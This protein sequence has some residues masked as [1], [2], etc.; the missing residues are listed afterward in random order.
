[1]NSPWEIEFPK[2][3]KDSTERS[4]TTVEMYK[5]WL[6]FIK[7]PLERILLAKAIKKLEEETRYSR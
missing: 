1:M 4:Y 7:D 3:D 6:T 2:P 5:H